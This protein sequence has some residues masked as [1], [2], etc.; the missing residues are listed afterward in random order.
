M[1]L[2]GDPVPASLRVPLPGSHR[3]SSI[4]G[5]APA[6]KR[7]FFMRA[8]L[9]STHIGPQS[10]LLGKTLARLGQRLEEIAPGNV[11]D[12]NILPPVPPVH[13]VVDS[14]ARIST[15]I[16][17]GMSPSL[18]NAAAGSSATQSQTAP[19]Q[20]DLPLTPFMRHR[21]DFR[22]TARMDHRRSESSLTPKRGQTGGHRAVL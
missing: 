2:S 6:P 5:G 7:G 21:H 22:S 1:P 3:R 19:P 13:R 18:P 4:V 11:I 16:V 8:F 20:T 10:L 14:G 17:R 9:H 12:E 15:R